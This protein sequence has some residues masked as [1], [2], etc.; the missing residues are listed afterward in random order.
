VHGK[1]DAPER[2]R[3]WI[4]LNWLFSRRLARVLTGTPALLFSLGFRQQRATWERRA[5][6]E[7][8]HQGVARLSKG[9]N[10]DQLFC[11][12]RGIEYPGHGGMYAPYLPSLQFER[13]CATGPDAPSGAA[14]FGYS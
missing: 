6:N 14:I 11:C 4:C 13:K 1:T 8:L 5:L 12:R 2:I 3:R 7:V 10:E 9:T